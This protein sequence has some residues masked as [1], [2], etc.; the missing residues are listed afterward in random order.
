MMGMN[1]PEVI[2]LH[3]SLFAL[4]FRFLLKLLKTFFPRFDFSSLYPVS[5]RA[6]PDA[7]YKEI[8]RKEHLAPASAACQHH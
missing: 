1:Q 6:H 4:S 3:V 2:N 7:E 5:H 8:L